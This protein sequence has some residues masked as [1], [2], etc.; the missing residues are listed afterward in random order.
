MYV[1]GEECV[2]CVQ[3]VCARTP[4]DAPRISMLMAISNKE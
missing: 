1:C 2:V 3:C 4:H